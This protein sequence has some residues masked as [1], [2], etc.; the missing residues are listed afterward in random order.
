MF[1]EAF[2]GEGRCQAPSRSKIE[3]KLAGG[4]DHLPWLVFGSRRRSLLPTF[5][6]FECSGKLG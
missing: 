5:V 1:L 4:Q 3:V 2:H 6:R